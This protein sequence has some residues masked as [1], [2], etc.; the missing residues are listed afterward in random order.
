VRVDVCSIRRSVG[1]SIASCQHSGVINR[2]KA[3]VLALFVVYWIAVLLIWIAARSVFD[4][5]GGLSRD[6]LPAEVGVVVVLTTLLMLL[7]IGVVRGWRW[8]F[9]L[10]LIAFLAGIVRVPIAVLELAG[11]VPHQGPAWYVLLTAVV[12]LSQFGIAAAMLAG[13]RQS[14]VWGEL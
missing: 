4:Q 7:S 13:Y 9:W 5:V 2:I 10:I 11:K 3:V 14:G 8:T 12:G 1:P 6:Q